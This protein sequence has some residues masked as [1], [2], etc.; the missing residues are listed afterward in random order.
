V[1]KV[2]SPPPLIHHILNNKKEHPAA[3]PGAKPMKSLTNNSFKNLP[4]NPESKADMT[5]ATSFR[6]VFG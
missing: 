4:M 6:G 1:A 5:S 3:L 2:G